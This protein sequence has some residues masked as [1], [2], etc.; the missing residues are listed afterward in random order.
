MIGLFRK[1]ARHLGPAGLSRTDTRKVLFYAESPV[2]YAMFRP[3]HERMRQ[4]PRLDFFF[5]GK[6][7]GASSARAMAHALG[8]EGMPAIRRGIAV[9]FPFDLMLSADYDLWEPFDDSRFAVSE[10][11]R[12]QLFHGASVRNGAIQPKLQRYHHLFSIGPYMGRAFAKADIIPEGDPRLRPVGM[13][14]TD[15]LLDGTLTREASRHKLGIDN[16]LPAVT[17]APTWVMRTPLNKYGEELLDALA[18]GPWNLLVKLHDK[19]FDPRYNTVD[20][21]RRLSEFKKTRGNVRVIENYDAMETLMATDVLISDVSSIANE[22][23]LLDRPLVYLA[24]EDHERMI[25]QYPW[26]DLETWGQRLGEVVDGPGACVSAVS[27]ALAD[28]SRHRD[29]RMAA[30]E[31]L[32]HNRGNATSAAV[33]AI[34][35]ILEMDEPAV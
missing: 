33:S 11:P 27:A 19:F 21:G 31:D 14:K 17:L 3:I 30:T 4:D 28:P 35:D 7:R 22:F 20:W 13:P 9:H 5:S 34:Y 26:L 24:I 29:I 15:R 12:I 2:K 23:A 6:L 1:A 32:F 10:T 16:D 25:R 8:V 18:E